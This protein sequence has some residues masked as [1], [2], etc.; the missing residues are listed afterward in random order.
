MCRLCHRASP[1]SLRSAGPAWLPHALWS[2][3]RP[4]VAPG[5][6]S[7][8]CPGFCPWPAGPAGHLPLTSHSVT[9][10]GGQALGKRW[11]FT[12]SLA[13]SVTARPGWRGCTLCRLPLVT[14]VLGVALC[15]PGSSVRV[16]ESPGSPP[17]GAEVSTAHPSSPDPLA[18]VSRSCDPVIRDLCT[19]VSRLSF[20]QGH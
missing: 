5:A 8:S 14:A 9:A 19:Q 13:S 12:P 4:N 16:L 20:P 1:G 11:S 7:C 18:T 3:C 2:P 10:Q 15:S 6:G 17:A